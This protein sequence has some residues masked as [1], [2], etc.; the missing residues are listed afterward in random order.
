[1]ITLILSGFEAFPF[2]L[3]SDFGRNITIDESAP[4]PRPQNVYLEVQ[5]LLLSDQSFLSRQLFGFSLQVKIFLLPLFWQ[6]F[7]ARTN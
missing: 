2:D 7:P 5:T 6:A 1:L 4:V 3:M